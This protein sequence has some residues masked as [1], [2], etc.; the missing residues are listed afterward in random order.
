MNINKLFDLYLDTIKK[1][2]SYLLESSEDDIGYFIFEEFDIGCVT[3]LHNDSLSRLLKSGK[4]NKTQ[5]NES[6]FLREKK[7]ELERSNKWMIGLVKEDERWRELFKI[8]DKLNESFR[9][10]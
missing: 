5:Y 7:I 4:I 6:I 10:D 1:C 8:A 2:G 9:L 3:F